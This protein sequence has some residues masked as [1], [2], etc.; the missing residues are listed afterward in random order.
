MPTSRVAVEIHKLLADGQ[1]TGAIARA[2]GRKVRMIQKH[3]VGE[4]T[5]PL[6]PLAQV[7]EV[8]RPADVQPAAL[9]A[10]GVVD[11]AWQ[12]GVDLAEIADT[13]GI[14]AVDVDAP[15]FGIGNAEISP[16]RIIRLHADA[17]GMARLREH[18]PARWAAILEARGKDE[19][20]A[21]TSGAIPVET[22]HALLRELR[23]ITGG[24]LASDHPDRFE[25]GP[26]WDQKLAEM[27][28]YRYP[29]IGLPE[30]LWPGYLT[31]P[32]GT[33]QGLFDAIEIY[34]GPFPRFHCADCGSGNIRVEI[35]RR[36][37]PTPSRL[38][39]MFRAVCAVRGGGADM[40]GGHGE[41]IHLHCMEKD[42]WV[43]PGDGPPLP[44]SALPDGP[45]CA[46]CRETLPEQVGPDAE[47]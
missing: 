22:V 26:F 42:D 4:C 19:R 28:G 44:L 3:R 20:K 34:A 9:D 16:R 27:L 21:A 39:T 33:A 2:V 18:H 30:G 12:S 29:E 47:G 37:S 14:G 38:E 24:M 1:R 17:A 36:N 10:V 45:I 32:D 41:I 35:D 8:E 6:P 40:I 7:T 5:C 43:G 46:R 23:R 31:N 25:D 11:M 13:L 15:D